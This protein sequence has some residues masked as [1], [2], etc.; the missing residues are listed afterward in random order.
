MKHSEYVEVIKKT[1]LDAGKKL[2]LG[3]LLKRVPFLFWGP[4]GAVTSLLVTKCLEI[5]I[6][7]TEFGIF[8]LY[9]DMRTDQQ[10]KE[11]SSTAMKNYQIQ[12]HGTPDEKKKSE[13]ELIKAFKSFVRLST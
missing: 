8:F 2:L 7:Q 10:G 4:L 1:A 9:I 13:E 6:Q 12:Q 11:F 5:L 3:E